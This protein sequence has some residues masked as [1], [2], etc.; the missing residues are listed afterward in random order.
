MLLFNT[1]QTGA[2]LLDSTIPFKQNV[3]YIC[4][5]VYNADNIHKPVV[6]RSKRS[7]IYSLVVCS[8]QI[9]S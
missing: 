7:Y 5:V 6:S 9:H 2:Q 1:K 3:I 4:T 8:I